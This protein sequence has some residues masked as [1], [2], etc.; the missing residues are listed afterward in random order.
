MNSDIK[1]TNINNSF[2][3][4]PNYESS[5]LESAETEGKEAINAID[6]DFSIDQLAELQE[7]SVLQIFSNGI[8]NSRHSFPVT[9]NIAK[10]V[11]A[12]DIF[13]MLLQ[14]KFTLN[15]CGIYKY[16]LDSS[17]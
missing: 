5:I 8:W 11:F 17:I 4:I 16:I 12:T 2:Q 10:M 9:D 6:I 7:T 3:F 15:S 1:K 14:R 13:K